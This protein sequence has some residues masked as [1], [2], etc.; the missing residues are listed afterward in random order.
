LAE[1][2][3]NLIV[4]RPGSELKKANEAIAIKPVAGG[5]LT[6]LTRK[7]Y[8]VLLYHAQEH[9]RRFPDVVRYSIPLAQLVATA[10]FDSHDTLLLREHML[11][12]KKTEVEWNDPGKS[13]GSTSLLSLI[14]FI[15]R[16]GRIQ[17]EWEYSS[18]II[19]LLLDPATFTRLSLV[20]QNRV[21]SHAALALYEICARYASNP[22][23]C[24]NRA[25]W[26]WWYPVLT[27][28]SNTDEVGKDP[29][30]YRYFKR[31]T[32]KPAIVEVNEL[33]DIAVELREFTRGRKV[34]AIQFLVSQKKQ[35]DLGLDEPPLIDSSLLQRLVALGMTPEDAQ[36]ICASNEE[37]YIRGALEATE[38]RMRS[39][40]G[41]KIENPAAYFKD[42][43]K[44]G[45]AKPVQQSELPVIGEFV[46]EKGLPSPDQLMESLRSAYKEA[47]QVDVRAMYHEQ[48]PAEQAIAL[49][50]FESEA[51]EKLPAQ[52]ATGFRRNGIKNKI[53]E[54]AF[55]QWLAART[56]P[57]PPTEKDLLSFGLEHRLLRASK[58]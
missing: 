23:G 56:W 48:T 16:D 22:S 58:G 34:E 31:D 51:L 14:E 21:R 13:W 46:E 39:K 11:R 3:A 28:R 30:F 27:G 53:V 26:Q 54:V 38:K 5:K 18:K 8:N 37:N 17:V 29:H 35:K 50:S 4:A 2:A 44:K 40:V 45:W 9:R 20:F 12:L 49:K 47:Q 33:T 52:I 10:E 41:A 57:G 36:T 1:P 19:S 15:K 24:T 55:F 25:E 43:L 32:L 6:L 42:T 7:V